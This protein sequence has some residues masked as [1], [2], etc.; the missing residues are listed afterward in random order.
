[1]L[2][3]SS[4]PNVFLTP[5]TV[6]SRDFDAILDLFE[7]KMA[8]NHHFDQKIVFIKDLASILSRS[9]NI[10]ALEEKVSCAFEKL[11]QTVNTTLFAAVSHGTLK[12]VKALV[13]IGADP[14]VEG[15][16]TGN[17]PLYYAISAFSLPKVK[18]LI[19]AGASLQTLNKKGEEPLNYLRFQYEEL[20]GPFPM[21]ILLKIF[22]YL[23]TQNLNKC[24]HVCKS[25]N[26]V[27]FSETIKKLS[28]ANND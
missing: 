11:T 21:E 27:V 5:N 20:K 4:R 19:E 22:S 12:H 8:I 14:A 25:W 16:E 24:L 3:Q 6:I 1:M 23:N 2:I 17:T 9:E 10:K 28:H 7:Q 18:F 26:L 15:Q 13:N